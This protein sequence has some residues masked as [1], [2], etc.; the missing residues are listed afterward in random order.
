[1]KPIKHIGIDNLTFAGKKKLYC[2]K[3]EGKS[4]EMIELHNS[5]R[6]EKGRSVRTR[7][8]CIPFETKKN[9]GKIDTVMEAV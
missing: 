4:R 6:E 2:S 7:R 3:N 9:R 1:M 5:H 8:I